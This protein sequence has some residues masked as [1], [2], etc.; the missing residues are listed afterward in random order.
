MTAGMIVSAGPAPMPLTT[1]A[2][3]KEPYEVAFA[4]QIDVPKLISWERRYTGRR[5]NDV[6]IGTLQI[7][8]LVHFSPRTQESCETIGIITYQ[9]KLLNPSTKIHTPVN[10]TASAKLQLKLSIK[11]GNI[12]ARDNGP[13]PC[14]NV[15]IAV[16]VMQ[17]A[18][19][20]MLQFNGS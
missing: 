3:I 14:V 6:L 4:R 12:G 7:T 15:T 2:P 5:P 19:Q 17:A 16:A 18:F 10:C 20:G 13:K 1:Q 11:A 8:V 9:I